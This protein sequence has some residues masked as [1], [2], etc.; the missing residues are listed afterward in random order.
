MQVF[1]VVSLKSKNN[2][3]SD[4]CKLFYD[5]RGTSWWLWGGVWVVWRFKKLK[6]WSWVNVRWYLLR[7]WGL[8]SDFGDFWLIWFLRSSEDFKISVGFWRF[9][10]FTFAELF[11]IFLVQFFK[12]QGFYFLFFREL[13]LD[14][15][16]FPTDQH[17]LF[18]RAFLLLPRPFSKNQ[19]DFFTVVATRK[20]PQKIKITTNNS[21]PTF[22]L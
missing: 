11:F 1:V 8:K 6:S 21:N 2:Q 9:R 12:D 4:I 17:K 3:K 14:Q 13:L 15:T 19:G 16:P 7:S 20:P 18:E 10:F 22:T 5:I